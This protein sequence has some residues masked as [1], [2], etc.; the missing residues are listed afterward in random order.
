MRSKPR[1][2]SWVVAAAFVFIGGAAAMVIAARATPRRAP[3]IAPDVKAMFSADI[4]SLDS[5]L[6]VL[7]STLGAQPAASDQ[8]VHAAFFRARTRYKRLE[9]IV[10]FY[11][12]ALAAAL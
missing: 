6:A 11:A 3:T 9:S 4:D 12:P 2:R 10:E 1:R 7:G 8:S 5:A